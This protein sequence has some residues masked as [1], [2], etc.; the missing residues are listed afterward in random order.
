MGDKPRGHL[1]FWT[2]RGKP[3]AR[4]SEAQRIR[5]QRHDYRHGRPERCA[6]FLAVG[7]HWLSGGLR[8]IRNTTANPIAAMRITAPAMPAITAPRITR[9]IRIPFFNHLFVMAGPSYR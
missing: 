8:D 5:H 4:R 6:G 2:R 3:P 9:F 7:G 1:L